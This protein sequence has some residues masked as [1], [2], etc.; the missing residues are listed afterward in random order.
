MAAREVHEALLSS[1]LRCTTHRCLA[2]YALMPRCQLTTPRRSSCLAAKKFG[3]VIKL[4]TARVQYS[5]TPLGGL[6]NEKSGHV[7]KLSTAGPAPVVS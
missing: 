3:Y 2:F 1:Y 5:A 7:I 6:V 4:C